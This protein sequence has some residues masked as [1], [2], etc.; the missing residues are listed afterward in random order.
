MSV[1]WSNP[2]NTIFSPWSMTFTRGA[3]PKSPKKLVF[4][5]RNTTFT[6]GPLSKCDWVSFE[7][8]LGGFCCEKLETLMNTFFVS[9]V[10][11]TKMYYAITMFVCFILDH[12][13]S[14]SYHVFLFCFV[15]LFVCFFD[16]EI[17][18]CFL[19]YL[20]AQCTCHGT[21]IYTISYS[22]APW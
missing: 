19:K 3:L 4:Y 2:I 16:M 6:W 10:A 12:F 7:E 1:G 22:K 9:I 15:C 11:F 8:Q 13:V 5:P 20:E 18:C 17:L 21:W 14:L